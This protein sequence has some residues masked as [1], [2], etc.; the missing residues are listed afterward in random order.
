MENDCIHEGAL[1]KTNGD[2]GMLIGWVRLIAGNAL[3]RWLGAGRSRSC[4]RRSARV[5]GEVYCPVCGTEEA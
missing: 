1:R 2:G 5:G 4:G 3:S